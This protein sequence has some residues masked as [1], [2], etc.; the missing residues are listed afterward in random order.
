MHLS[1]RKNGIWGHVSC[2]YSDLYLLLHLLNQRERAGQKISDRHMKKNSNAI[3]SE[4]I[5]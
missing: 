3:V 1:Q 5:Q 2:E 4:K